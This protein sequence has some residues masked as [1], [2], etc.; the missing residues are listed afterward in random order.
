MPGVVGDVGPPRL[1]E[2]REGPH[3][4]DCAERAEDELVGLIG[5]NRTQRVDL[6]KGLWVEAVFHDTEPILNRGEQLRVFVGE[7]LVWMGDER[8]A[9]EHLELELLSFSAAKHWLPGAHIDLPRV[10]VVHDVRRTAELRDCF[11]DRER[12]PGIAGCDDRAELGEVH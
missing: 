1:T 12:G 11:G 5:A 7:V 6:G 9:L 4:R 8:C 3:V 10:A 2:L